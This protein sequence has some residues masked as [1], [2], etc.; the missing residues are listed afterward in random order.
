VSSV[1]LELAQR[2]FLVDAHQ[3]TVAGY[4]ASENRRQPSVHSAFRH[5]V[6]PRENHYFLKGYHVGTRKLVGTLPDKP[7]A[8]GHS[9]C[10]LMLKLI[11][12]DKPA[13]A[14][15]SCCGRRVHDEDR[16]KVPLRLYYI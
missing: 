15:M 12:S 16:W 7:P 6:A 11:K 9:R 1:R 14:T 4:V 3:P 10:L 2:A 8:W 5:L 13:I